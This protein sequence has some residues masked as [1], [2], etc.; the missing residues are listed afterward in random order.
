MSGGNWKEMFDAACEGDLQLLAYHVDSGIDVN[1]AHPE[2]LATPL[3]ACILARREAAA[4]YLLS[5]GADPHLLSE[6]DG[7]TPA[8]AAQQAGL[9]TVQRRLHE[10]GAMA[11]PTTPPAPSRPWWTRLLGREDR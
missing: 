11:P 1:Y 5:H 10:L 4:L 3:V 2:Y 8:Q 6:S 7:C 9:V